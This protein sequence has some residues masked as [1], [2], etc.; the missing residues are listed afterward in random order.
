MVPFG[1]ENTF[2]VID[3]QL[4]NILRFVYNT[5][6]RIENKESSIGRFS[7]LEP[8]KELMLKEVVKAHQT[9]DH[10]L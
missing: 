1:A 7:A 5:S 3:P 9:P 4:Q 8:S 10:R 6:H 2:M